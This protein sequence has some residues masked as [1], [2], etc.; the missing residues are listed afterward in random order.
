[1]LYIIMAGRNI[2][3]ETKSELPK[4]LWNVGSE[5]VIGR[6][7]RLLRKCGVENIAI[8]TN[9]DR[10]SRFG[11]RLLRHTNKGSWINGFYPTCEPTC[12]IFGDVVFSE[13]AMRTVVETETDSVEFFASAPPFHEDYTKPWA[14]PFAFKVVDTHYFRECIDEVRKGILE[15][16]WKRDPIAWELWQVVK[17]TPWNRIDYT[18][19]TVINDWTCDV[20]C[21]D[22][23]KHFENISEYEGQIDSDTRY[24][25][26]ACPQ[27]MWYVEQFLVPSMLEQGIK[28][29]QITIY[30]DENG[31]GN[32]RA[33]MESY[34]TLPD[35]GRGTWHL[36][37][38]VLI[39]R[40]FKE[41]TEK[42]DSGFIAGFGSVMYDA[43]KD[44]GLANLG[45]IWWSF[46]CIRIP[47]KAARDCAEWVLEYIIGNPVYLNK[48][49]EGKGD[50]WAFKLYAQNFLKDKK[51]LQ[52]LPTLVE[53]V[54]YLIGWSS[55][56]CNRSEPCVSLG[57]K[58]M[59]LV[60][61]L[62]RRL[63]AWGA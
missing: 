45:D 56:G 17:K 50:D 63:E 51:C 27:R 52:L 5:T 28:R 8:S 15:G 32:L 1:M 48:T 3:A 16:K 19:Y 59:D 54:D 12:Y 40:D 6:T 4:Q 37:D 44:S 18:N 33:C 13:D 62:K 26:H 60:E 34:L 39:C 24:M 38:D 58:D 23:L 61:D 55:I 46:P 47:N 57:F 14:E 42:H 41:R 22:D 25:I 7:I 35:N 31:K 36:Q 30:C 2:T 21:I 53:H 43:N 11:L 20:D 10:F 9:D 29:E 49:K